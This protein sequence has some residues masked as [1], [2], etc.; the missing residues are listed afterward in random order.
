MRVCV[1]VCVCVC[2]RMCVCKKKGEKR[3]REI[4]KIGRKKNW[5]ENRKGK[6]E[7]RIQGEEY[8]KCEIKNK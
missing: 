1:C 8:K 4:K 2:V 6:K 3:E 7:E 5:K